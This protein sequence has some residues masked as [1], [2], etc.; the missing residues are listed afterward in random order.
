MAAR[1]STLAMIASAT[2]LTH[3]C[4][5]QVSGAQS[6]LLTSHSHRAAWQMIAHK[7]LWLPGMKKSDLPT[8][9][10][11]TLSAI[12]GAIGPYHADINGN[13]GDGGIR[14]PFDIVPVKAGEVPTYPA[15]WAHTTKEQRSI[16]FDGDSQGCSAQR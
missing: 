13:T 8:L 4:R 12:G 14:G 15:L 5:P 1:Q 10:V 11:K 3:R 2:L 7:H 6:E 16:S 9:N